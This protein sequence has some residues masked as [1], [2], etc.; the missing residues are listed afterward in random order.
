MEI[1][2]QNPEFHFEK[3][4][5]NVTGPVN[6]LKN[7][8]LFELG[9]DTA[10]QDDFDA[11]RSY[12][13]FLQQEFDF[14][15]LMEYFDESLVLLKRRFCWTTKDIL[16]FKLNERR[17]E[18]KQNISK[19]SKERIQKWNFGDVLLYDVFNRTLWEMIRHEGPGFF[20]DL[21]LFR[22]AKETM[23]K[24][25]LREGNFL[26]RPYRG[27]LVKGYALK[28]NISSEVNDT[29][30]KMVM[31]EIPFVNHHRRKMVKLFQRIDSAKNRPNFSSS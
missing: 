29:C 20:K 9:L 1:F 22:K 23:T 15:I 19:Y 2:L 5:F 6:L 16:Y 3:L 28:R 30:N 10:D 4:H 25:C 27:R 11:V 17:N 8:A 31:N 18:D 7:P 21:E 24:A 13:R 14:V 12:I 26:T